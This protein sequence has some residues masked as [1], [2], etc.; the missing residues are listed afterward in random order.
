M[1]NI[2]GIIVSYIFIFLI[3]LSA[4]MF[5]KS[6]K[7]ATRKYIH[8]MLCNWWFI[9]S[10]FFN[11][12]FWASIVP[13]TFV[14]INY[15]SYQKGIID[16]ME[17]EKSKQ[18]GLGTVY[19]AIS[20]FILSIVSFGILKRAEIGL[21][22]ILTMGYGDGLAAV[23]GQTIKSK[24]Y[25]IGSSKKTIIGSITMFVVTAIILSI[26]FMNIPYCYIKVL[27]AS[28]IITIVEAVSIRGTDN[29]TV[30]ILTSIIIAILI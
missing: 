29:L 14:I 13:L 8:I 19:Y 20:L 1:R 15:I 21:A 24:E 3:I 4:K 6:G 18:D 2:I 12:V 7:E 10:Y 30:P 9:A 5:E 23:V 28:F 11:N 25:Q 22:G 27:V 17:R 16:I 26:F